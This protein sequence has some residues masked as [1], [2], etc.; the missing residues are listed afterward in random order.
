MI[1][2]GSLAL[3]SFHGGGPLPPF[4]GHAVFVA[5]AFLGGRIVGPRR[6]PLPHCPTPS[7]PPALLRLGWWFLGPCSGHRPPGMIS[8]NSGAA[9]AKR[10]PR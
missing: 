8:P 6:Q 3:I 7:E 2:L 10:L 5:L 9:L 4:L 1:V